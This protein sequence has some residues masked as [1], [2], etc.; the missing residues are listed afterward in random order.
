ME[1]ASFVVG[2]FLGLAIVFAANVIHEAWSNAVFSPEAQQM[3]DCMNDCS[4]A[5]DFGSPEF[6]ACV[7]RCLIRKRGGAPMRGQ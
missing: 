6:N 3:L 7:N 1:P 5:G 2:L 4:N